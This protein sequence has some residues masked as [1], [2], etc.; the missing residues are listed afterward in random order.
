[1]KVW[2]S[3]L[4]SVLRIGSLALW[5]LLGAN[6]GWT[7]TQ[8]FETQIDPITQIEFVSARRGFQPGLDLLALSWIAAETLSLAAL[9]IRK[10]N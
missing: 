2:L 8:I 6:L 5:F 3:A 1:M 10:R 9:F 4:A 7:K